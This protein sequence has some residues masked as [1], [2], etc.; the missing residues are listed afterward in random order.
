MTDSTRMTEL[1]LLVGS[2]FTTRPEEDRELFEE[3]REWLSDIQ[4]LLR[5]EGVEVDLLSRPGVEIWEGGIDQFIDL[6]QL[7]L[8]AAYL[9][10]GRDIGPLRTIK[11]DT[12]T[13]PDPLLAAIWEDE[14]ATRFPHLINHQADGGYYLP[15]DFPEPIWLEFDEDEG[16]NHEEIQEPVV[17]FGSSIALQRELVE[18]EPMLRQAGVSEKSAPY[19]CLV[20]LREA[21]DQSVANDLPII[22]W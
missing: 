7:R 14:Q 10:Q 21:A 17:S 2:I 6:Y 9:E 1:D 4:D 18:L 11:P 3:E 8:L 13:E 12:E 20:A 5:E 16:D 15:V 22:I 19:R